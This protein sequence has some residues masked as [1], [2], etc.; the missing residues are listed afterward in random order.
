MPPTEAI[1]APDRAAMVRSALYRGYE[2]AL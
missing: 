2:R 1:D